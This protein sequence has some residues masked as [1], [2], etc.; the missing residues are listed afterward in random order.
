MYE[1]HPPNQPDITAIYDLIPG[2]EYGC[3]QPGYLPEVEWVDIEINGATVGIELY[4]FLI[5]KFGCDWGQEI[6]NRIIAKGSA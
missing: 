1:Y 5:E 4:S 6:I 2:Q 3:D